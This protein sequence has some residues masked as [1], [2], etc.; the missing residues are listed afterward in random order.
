METE[1]IL[2]A[3]SISSA[4]LILIAYKVIIPRLIDRTWHKFQEWYSIESSAWQKNIAEAINAAGKEFVTYA[5]AKWSELPSLFEDIG[6]RVGT[7]AFQRVA[8]SAGVQRR[9]EIGQETDFVT[10]II[11]NN[12]PEYEPLWNMAPDSIK[13]SIIAKIAKDPEGAMKYL[14]MLKGWMGNNGSSSTQNSGNMTSLR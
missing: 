6:G 8:S 10:N 3:S 11:S 13:R 14:G 2:L 12:F 1:L 4:I 7:A 9:Q 5:N